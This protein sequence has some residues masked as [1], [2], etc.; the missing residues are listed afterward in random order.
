MNNETEK[1]FNTILWQE[2]P[3]P[4]TLIDELGMSTQLLSTQ[5]MAWQQDGQ[6]F[7]GVKILD[8]ET[9]PDE[10]KLKVFGPQPFWIHLVYSL[11]SASSVIS[12]DVCRAIAFTIN[13]STYPQ[14]A[15]ALVWFREAIGEETYQRIVAEDPPDIFAIMNFLQAQQMEWGRN[16]MTDLIESGRIAYDSAFESYGIERPEARQVR[17]KEEAEFLEPCVPHFAAFCQQFPQISV[18]ICSATALDLRKRNLS[19]VIDLVTGV[20]LLCQRTLNN[21]IEKKAELPGVVIYCIGEQKLPPDVLRVFLQGRFPM[22]MD[23]YAA[24]LQRIEQCIA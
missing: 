24:H 18:G 23:D 16:E 20:L 9:D 3:R 15:P 19:T 7:A 21:G 11:F 4:R 13:P 17:V 5:A 12:G 14:F 2:T 6:M 10:Y 22:E 1:P 8:P